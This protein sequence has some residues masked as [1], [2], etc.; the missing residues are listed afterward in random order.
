MTVTFAVQ[1]ADEPSGSVAVRVTF[2]VPR[3]YGPG[4]DCLSVTGAA[5]KQYQLANYRS[6]T[7]RAKILTVS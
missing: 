3:G 4:G 2:V 1:E 7:D 5:E 6:H